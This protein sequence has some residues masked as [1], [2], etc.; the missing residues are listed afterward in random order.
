[1]STAQ[2]RALLAGATV[3][4]A[5]F[6]PAT[7]AHGA[8]PYWCQSSEFCLWDGPGYGGQLYRVDLRTAPIGQCVPLPGLFEARSWINRSAQHITVYLSRKCA[9]EDQFATYPGGGTY[10]PRAPYVGRGVEVW[11]D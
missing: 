8:A 1:M 2:R 7:P 10:V 3:I 11:A 6:A 4:S 9:T 5:L